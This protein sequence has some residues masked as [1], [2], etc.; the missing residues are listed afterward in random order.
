MPLDQWMRGP[1]KE[2]LV[3][4][5]NSDYLKRQ[6]IFDE[7]YMNHF[8][9]KYLATGDKGSGTGENYS[10]IMWAFFVLQQW[11]QTYMRV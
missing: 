7:V 5:C 9:K 1:L 8:L 10:R 6:G 2:Q 3:D 11:Y 4:M